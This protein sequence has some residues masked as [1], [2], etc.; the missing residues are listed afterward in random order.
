MQLPVNNYLT[1]QQADPATEKMSSQV[2]DW[3]EPVPIKS[4]LPSWY[5]NLPANLKML[6][7]T[8]VTEDYDILKQHGYRSAKLCLGLRG[9][10][11]VGWTIP[12]TY[13]LTFPGNNTGID[14]KET[15]L[16]PAM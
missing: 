4:C 7:L 12:L 16:H 14:R 3:R 9:I 15:M 6:N 13:D 5:T 10:R 2:K 1:W 11:T 8:S